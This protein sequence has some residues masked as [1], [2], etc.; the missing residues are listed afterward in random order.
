MALDDLKKKLTRKD[1]DFSDRYTH[2]FFEKQR[3]KD[4]AK[5]DW[6]YQE[7]VSMPRHTTRKKTWLWITAGVLLVGGVGTFGILLLTG[8]ISIGSK[9]NN[10][11]EIKVQGA[12]EVVSG[13]KS[14]WK[15]AYRNQNNFA[16]E[17]AVLTFEFPR[18]AQPLAGDFTGDGLRRQQVTIGNLAAGKQSEETFS[19]ILFGSQND[20]LPGAV[21]LEYRPEGSS[22][23]LE[24]KI[25]FTSRVTRSLLGLKVEVPREVKAAQEMDVKLTISSTSESPFRGLW[26][27]VS[28]PE[29]FEFISA[30]PK[31]SRGNT[32]WEI[33]NLDAGKE[34]TIT[35]RGRVKESVSAQSIRAEVGH[36]ERTSSKFSSFTTVTESFQT[37]P[38]FLAVGFETLQGQE[39]PG[40][41]EAG[42][43]LVVSVRWRNNLPVP[44]INGQ[45]EVQF[46][47]DAINLQTIR[48]ETGEFNAE[49][50]AL[51][52]VPGRSRDLDVVD[53]GEEGAFQFE[54]HTK[55]NL[56]I[57]NP[58][59]KLTGTM[60]SAEAPQG[61][62][63]VDVRGTAIEEYRIASE[64]AFS[65]KG[66]FHDS[67]VANSGPLPPQVGQQ[68]TYLIV[69]SI[70]NTTSDISSPVVRA[71]LPSY[72]RW[73]GKVIPASSGLS[74]DSA[75]REVTWLPN[76][77]RA[78]AGYARRAEEVA[79]QI[80]ITPSTPQTGTTPELIS[81][82]EFE[83]AD[84]FTGNEIRLESRDITTSLPDDPLASRDGGTVRQ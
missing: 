27:Q 53:P 64:V 41:T 80:A 74:F 57:E 15:V 30:S 44:V 59:I 10:N 32:L 48:S 18:G 82:A 83:G 20:E 45:V 47:G 39:Q 9:A 84:A 79:F 71:T 4:P 34:V 73:T 33:G 23:R 21:I 72:I 38:S 8:N 49:R 65:Q 55:E 1:Q 50:N 69:W 12:E 63:G 22:V 76:V 61:Y 26:A 52:W 62:E 31:P 54:F 60:S 16:L 5:T 77:V 35:V 37:A 7:G 67:R 29:A 19:A 66:F 56:R 58:M 6:P 2:P 28:Y 42:G 75:T 25:E 24:K 17:D 43:Q 81:E 3:E 14:I 13:D 78:G 36:F 46:E 40:V 11:I 70:T 51:V 68:T